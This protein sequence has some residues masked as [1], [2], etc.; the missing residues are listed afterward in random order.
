MLDEEKFNLFCMKDQRYV[1]SLMSTYGSLNTREDQK[2][3]MREMNGEKAEFHFTESI[4]NHYEYRD[5]VDAHN[6]KRH[7]C[8]TKQGLGLE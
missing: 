1:M 5:A 7:D 2:I 8:G 4:D 6:A 3:S